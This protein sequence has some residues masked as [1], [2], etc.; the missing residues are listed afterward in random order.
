MANRHRHKQ[1]EIPPHQQIPTLL[2]D[3]TAIMIAHRLSTIR[4]ADHIF[5]LRQGEI[6]EDGNHQELLKKD[7]EYARL[8]R[9]QFQL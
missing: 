6:L 3:R 5:V 4:E 8:I 9:A 2:K 7:G 1:Q